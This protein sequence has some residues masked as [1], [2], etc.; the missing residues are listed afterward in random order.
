MGIRV[1]CKRVARLLRG[2]GRVQPHR[3][4]WSIADHTRSDLV[5]DA[6]YRPVES[7]GGTAQKNSV[8]R[9]CAV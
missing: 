5:V 3:L 7:E 8:R 6:L 4:G 9:S 2:S 1:D